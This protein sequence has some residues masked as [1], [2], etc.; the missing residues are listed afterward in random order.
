MK[1]ETARVL[2]SFVPRFEDELAVTFNNIVT[3]LEDE[4]NPAGNDWVLVEYKGEKGYIPKNFIEKY[5]IK[6][7]EVK[8]LADFKPEE[9]D[10]KGQYLPFSKGE[11]LTLLSY[12]ISGWDIVYKDSQIGA[13]PHTY[14]E[15]LNPTDINDIREVKFSLKINIFIF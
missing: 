15:I 1:V 11:I 14:I 3:I 8:A 2:C 13:I 5:D 4:T 10:P 9:S 12:D 6:G 7:I